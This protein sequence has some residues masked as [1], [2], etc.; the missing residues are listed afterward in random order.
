MLPLPWQETLWET[1]NTSIEQERLPHALLIRGPSG[2]GKLRLAKAL[3]QHLLCTAEMT[4]YACGSCKGCQ[5][6]AAGSHG[7][8]TYLEPE[9]PG[10]PIK[11]DPVRALCE[12]LGKTAQ[13]GGWKV[14]IIAPAETMNNNAANALLKN[15]EEPQPKTLLI[16]VSHRPS[17]LSATI[18]SRCQKISMPIPDT[19]VASQ[20]LNEV[21]GDQSA[22]DK[23]LFLAAG[24]P[25]LALDYLQSDNLQQRQNFEQLIA[26]VRAGD[27]SPLEAAQQ[28]QKLDSTESID[29]FSSYVHRL[30][31]TD[32]ADQPIPA[33]FSFSDKLLQAR[34]WVV[35]G[36]NPNPQLLWEELFMDWLMVFAA[37]R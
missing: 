20:W 3:A 9:E 33:L 14:A 28:A 4:K 29:W 5:L 12:S 24:K 31:T 1:L 35:S 26:E 8:I 34:N 10:K 32:L 18:R 19:A 6:L 16:L 17:Q 2:I 27:I 15:L 30:A 7:D 21:T 37:R 13:Q 22:V 11:I 25:L 36:N 23:V